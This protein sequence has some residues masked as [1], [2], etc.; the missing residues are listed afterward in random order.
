RGMDSAK[1]AALQQALERDFEITPLPASEDLAPKPQTEATTPLELGYL[2]GEGR[3]LRLELKDQAIAEEALQDHSDAYRHLDTGVLETLILKGALG[4]SDDDTP[5]FNGLFY[6]RDTAE[7]EAMVAGGEYEAAFLMRPTP[8]TQVR[9]IAAA[10]E[11]M[12]PK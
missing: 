6:A 3:R 1:R 5:P 8:V 9:E 12:P 4:L 2:D 7:A 11:N 10:G